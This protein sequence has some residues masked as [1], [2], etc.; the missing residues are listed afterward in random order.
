MKIRKKINRR[1]T[2]LY[3]LNDFKNQ[4]IQCEKH[5]GLGSNNGTTIIF[6][7]CIVNS[8]IKQ[9]VQCSPK[10]AFLK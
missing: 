4:F 1:K 5:I 8:A 7:F 6:K 2:N 9:A 3:L 10:P